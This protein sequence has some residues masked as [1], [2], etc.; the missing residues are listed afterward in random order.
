MKIQD[1]P[2]LMVSEVQRDSP[3]LKGKVSRWHWVGEGHIA[4]LYVGEGVFVEGKF[5]N[6]DE[7]S[8]SV[9]FAVKQL[10]PVSSIRAGASI[11]YF[12]GYWGER[13]LIAL[14]RLLDWQEVS[15]E[16]RDAIKTCPDG[17]EQVIPGG[18]DH[19]HCAICWVT[20]SQTMNPRFMKSSQG[21]NVCLDCFHNHVEPRNIDFIEEA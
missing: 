4:Y 6:V 11:P 1:L 9:C 20:I 5:R 19:E 14:D 16:P 2:V 21:D 7:P 15:F 12:D 13:A 18:W 10:E 17:T 8:R 3:Q